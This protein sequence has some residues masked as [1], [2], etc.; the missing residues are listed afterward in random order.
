M[1][2]D[3]PCEDIPGMLVPSRS[4]SPFREALADDDLRIDSDVDIEALMKDKSEE[5]I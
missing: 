1:I 3:D 5:D 4:P 2:I